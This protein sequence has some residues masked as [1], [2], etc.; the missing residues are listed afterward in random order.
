METRLLK[1]SEA[2]AVLAVSVRGV[3]AMLSAGKLPAEA[4]VRIGRSVRFRADVLES[5]I[6]EGCPLP[7]GRKVV[8]R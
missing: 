3:W 7:S 5:W 8:R 6:R 2:A 4:V 1:V